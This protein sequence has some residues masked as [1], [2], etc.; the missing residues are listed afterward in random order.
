M[1]YKDQRK[2]DWRNIFEAILLEFRLSGNEL[3]SIAGI[4]QSTI[5]RITRGETPNPYPATIR[6]IEEA[7]N[8][9]FI[10]EGSRIRFVK[11]E[12]GQKLIASIK[13]NVIFEPKFE[14]V[15]IPLV[16][17]KLFEKHRK[18]IMTILK[19]EG[20][21]STAQLRNII[22][23][24]INVPYHSEEAFA[25]IIQKDTNEPL[26]MKNDII[27]F[28][29]LKPILEGDLCVGLIDNEVSFLARLEIVNENKYRFN[30]ENKIYPPIETDPKNIISMFKAKK[31]IRDLL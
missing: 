29:M 12:R 10:E 26:I 17:D 8:I 30:F 14:E 3:A 15:N 23:E 28:D 19:S 20:A 21:I 5:S 9:K 16:T 25:A 31:I 24:S 7:L 2:K 13:K 6:K 18:E 4:R 27:I 22:K 11:S 1:N